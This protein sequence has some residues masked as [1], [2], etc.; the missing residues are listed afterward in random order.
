MSWY[1]A[2]LLAM[3]QL[4]AAHIPAGGNG[5]RILDDLGR[6]DM[7]RNRLVRNVGDRRDGSPVVDRLAV[8]RARRQLAVV[9]V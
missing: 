4:S 7:L 9:E 2:V 5:R 8:R 1:N 3:A 6:E